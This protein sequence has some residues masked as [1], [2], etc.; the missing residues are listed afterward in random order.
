M[1]EY[2]RRKVLQ[3]GAAVLGGI[4]LG[5]RTVSAVTASERRFFV[6]METTSMDEMGDVEVVY[7]LRE[8]TGFAV[9]E[10]GESALPDGAAYAPDMTVEIEVP[11][12]ETMDMEA[13]DAEEPFYGLQWDKQEQNVE[14]V[15]ET[16]TGEGTRIG[17][18]DDGVLGANPDRDVVHPD[19]PDVNEELSQNFTDDGN[20]PGP[21]NDDHGTHCAGT[22]AA[23]DNGTGVVGVAPDAE[24]VDLRVFSG[25]GA[26]FA[27]VAAAV[28]VGGAPEGAQ[29][30]VGTAENPEV[31]TGAGC[32]VLNLSLGSGPLPPSEP[33]QVVRDAQAA[34]AQFALANGCLPIASAGN[35]STNL[36]ASPEGF[37]ESFVNLPSEADGFMSIGAAGPVG[38]G[39]P[40]GED[41]ETIAGYPV[42]SDPQVEL[43][44]EEPAF[45]TNY[46]AEGVD[47][48]AGGGNADLDALNAADGPNAFYDLVFSTGIANLLPPDPDGD[49]EAE[50]PE[51]TVLDEYVPG[52]VFKAGTS[53]SAPNVAGIA[54]VLFSVAPD[55]GPAAVRAAI[56]D[57]AQPRPV[58]RAAETTA[59]GVTPNESQ[60]GDFDGD[61]PSSPGSVPGRL[62]PETYRGEG[63]V[64]LAAAVE[65]IGGEGVDGDEDG[66][67]RGPPS[68]P[69]GRGRG[70]GGN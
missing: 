18:V 36:D 70:R 29:V 54:A 53:F 52:Y 65:Q 20:G 38:F 21:L 42:E 13:E 48:T 45:Y 19:L 26:S 61:K 58:G 30:N 6:D 5:T 28:V 39:W 64:N 11:E 35:D 25:Q 14:A 41:A 16:A 8:R 7:D 9:V 44:T 51:D 22:A 47:V 4:A 10:G 40:A 60:D 59:P 50:N 49:G 66:G 17:I 37:E 12:Q 34:A 1:S 33:V 46:G 23:A 15:H 55:A 24:I 62:D 3:A 69:P 27:D 67:G 32:D 56:E 57:T 31:Y 68:D 63:H 43:P 2:E